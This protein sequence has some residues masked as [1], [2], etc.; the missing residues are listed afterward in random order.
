[1]SEGGGGSVSCV[2]L[3]VKYFMV[4]HPTRRYATGPARHS[5]SKGPTLLLFVSQS[6]VDKLV[7]L[8]VPACIINKE[9]MTSSTSLGYH[10]D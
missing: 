8:S 1:M 2:Y 9:V 10:E 5:D 6:M 3:M 4:G 7:N